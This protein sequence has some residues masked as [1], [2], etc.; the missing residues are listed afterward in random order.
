M[1]CEHN[2]HDSPRCS[3]QLLVLSITNC[4]KHRVWK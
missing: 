2:L 4:D 1:V 3:D